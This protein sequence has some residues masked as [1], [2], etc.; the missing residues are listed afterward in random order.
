MIV[1]LCQLV[2]PDFSVIDGV[3]GMQGKG[4]S[5]GTPKEAGILLGGVNPHAVDLAGV[6]VMGFKTE[7]VPTVY[8]AQE[9]GII[10]KTPYE[11]EY[12]GDDPKVHELHFVPASS[13]V[14]GFLIR[15]VPEKFRRLIGCLITP[16]PYIQEKKCV[17]CG[18]CARTC[19]M[20]TIK[21][22]D[23]KA[24]IDY[25]QCVK[26][27]CCHELCPPKAIGFKRIVKK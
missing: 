18:A 23:G 6:R 22:V 15:L 7:D 14:P 21:I 11:L 4:P 2:S 1:D 5:G 20:H 9:R 16:Y 8:D 19:P 26:C 24:K 27:Y 3:V 12:L 13:K 10:P 25:S 17:G